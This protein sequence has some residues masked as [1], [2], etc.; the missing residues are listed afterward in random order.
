[1]VSISLPIGRLR[2][3]ARDRG[4]TAAIEFAFVAGPF[5]FMLFALIELA[6]IF[7]LSTS[8]D[9]ASDRASREIRTGQFQT[10]ATHT[11]QD[12]KDKICNGMT[13]LAG[14]CGSS[15]IVAVTTYDSYTQWKA[16][17]HEQ[18]TLVNGEWTMNP[19]PD[20]PADIPPSRIVVVQS[21][22]KWPLI[23]PFVSALQRLEGGIAV[24]SSTQTFRTEPYQ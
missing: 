15:L 11:K 23:T 17:P 16:A 18:F 12:F 20:F 9:A 24:V 1:M 7:L 14:N 5:L 8:L 19:E 2:D 6:L 10:A 21:Y 22:Y 13:W 3:F 4:G